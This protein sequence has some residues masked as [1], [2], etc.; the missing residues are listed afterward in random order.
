MGFWRELGKAPGW[1]AKKAGLK[2]DKNPAEGIGQQYLQNVPQYGHEAFDQYTQQ[3]KE[4]WEKALPEYLKYLEPHALLGADLS[5]YEPSAYYQQMAPFLDTSAANAAR[6][7]GYYGSDADAYQRSEITNRFLQGD[8]GN[9]L[10]RIN[11]MRGAGIQGF[12][13]ALGRGF[14][15]NA[16]LADYLGN[17]AGNRANLEYAGKAQQGMN[18]TQRFHDLA[19]LVAAVFGAQAGQKGLEQGKQQPQGGTNNPA[20]VGQQPL[21]GIQTRPPFSPE[22][23]YGRAGY[24]PGQ[25]GRGY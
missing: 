6:A 1:I 5:E 13:S 10:D 14:Q 8:I 2:E 11:N 9:Y 17:A 21:R 3:G 18:Q 24:N 4:A 23:N 12:E 15:G 7:G 16:S 25:I 20:G 22:I 19:S